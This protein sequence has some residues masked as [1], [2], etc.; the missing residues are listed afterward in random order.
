M[1]L[2]LRFSGVKCV[3][4]LTGNKIPGGATLIFEVELLDIGKGNHA[5]NY[6]KE[7]DTDN[8][9]LLSQDEVM[10]VIAVFEVMLFIN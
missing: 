10:S 6:F 2:Y 1:N 9:N 4:S 8:D 7:I 5:V 3:L